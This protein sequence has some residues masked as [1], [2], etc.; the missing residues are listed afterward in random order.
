M[1][2]GYGS[3]P[4]APMRS[5]H[6]RARLFGLLSV[7]VAAITGYTTWHVV[8]Q[9]DTELAEASGSAGNLE[10]VLAAHDLKPGQIIT[11]SDVTLGARPAGLGLDEAFFSTDN[12]VG[13]MVHDP[14]PTGAAI[15]HD[16]RAVG[17]AGLTAAD[18]IAPGARAV[19]VHVN[20]ASAV[21]G[22]IRPGS[23]VDVIVTIRPDQK[24][25]GAN[26]V[27]DT[28]LQGVRVL[29]VGQDLLDPSAQSN[30]V[31]TDSKSHS[32]D[33]FVT[34]EV[35]PAESE[36]V[37][38]VASRGQ[39]QLALRGRSDLEIVKRDGPLVTNA[40]IGVPEPVQQ[41]QAQRVARVKADEAAT[42][43]TTRVIRGNKVSVE[44]FTTPTHNVD[45][46]PAAADR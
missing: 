10:I 32:K 31:T 15:K 46:L 29:A 24:D 12:V 5:A 45:T 1:T 9:Y 28:I 8:S 35:S 36:A 22:L 37:A 21:G 33:E 14:T 4:S 26:W 34:L 2:V 40:L 6:N 25:L 16:A 20:Q 17:G 44:Q 43:T 18:L 3:D 30:D 19:T 41:A 38:L 13:Q 23:F 39:I 42:S 7:A 11:S 27:T